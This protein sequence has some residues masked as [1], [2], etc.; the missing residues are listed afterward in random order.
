MKK[1]R[2]TTKTLSSKQLARRWISHNSEQF[3]MKYGKKSYSGPN[4][5]HH[6]LQGN[7][8]NDLKAWYVQ[9]GY[10]SPSQTI[11]SLPLISN[12]CGKIIQDWI[13]HTGTFLKQKVNLKIIFEFL[14][15]TGNLKW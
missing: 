4:T 9:V 11:L 10:P 7:F 12:R 13:W 1:H 3:L 8:W 2:Q 14:P 5:L 15:P 6:I